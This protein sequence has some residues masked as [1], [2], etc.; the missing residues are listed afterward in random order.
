M[1]MLEITGLP[2]SPQLTTPR[3]HIKLLDDKGRTYKPAGIATRSIEDRK[4]NLAVE[5]MRPIG[6]RN[7]APTYLFL[8][9]PGT[10]RFKLLLDPL[11]PVPFTASR[12]AAP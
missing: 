6:I 8:V 12:I 7:E 2:P 11:P 9:P 3:D 4:S 1:L 10:T 5:Y